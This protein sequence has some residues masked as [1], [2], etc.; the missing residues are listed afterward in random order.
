MKPTALKYTTVVRRFHNTRAATGCFHDVESAQ[1]EQL[2]PDESCPPH[3]VPAIYAARQ[4]Q[5]RKHKIIQ[6][7]RRM[8]ST[9]T[10]P[11]VRSQVSPQQKEAHARR[12][13]RSHIGP[14]RLAT[15]SNF[16]ASR[17][18]Y[19]DFSS[20]WLVSFVYLDSLLS[21]SRV[22]RSQENLSGIKAARPCVCPEC[23]SEN[24]WC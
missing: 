1:V 2:Q 3:H 7:E 23:L 17:V 6:S 15:S 9:Q 18:S 14:R 24:E 11:S 21:S 13:E 20:G 12:T 19:L 22:V 4:S 10:K 8:S 5:A 16:A